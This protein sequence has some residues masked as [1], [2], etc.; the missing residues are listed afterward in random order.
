MLLYRDNLVLDAQFFSLGCYK[1]NVIV[2]W[3]SSWIM[4]I[5]RGRCNA[6]LIFVIYIVFHICTMCNDHCNQFNSIK[7]SIFEFCEDLF[8]LLILFST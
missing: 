3:I 8:L 5:E 1:F 2:G 4:Y 6:Y 7:S